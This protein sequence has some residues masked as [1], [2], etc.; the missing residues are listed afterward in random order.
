MCQSE[1]ILPWKWHFLEVP[2]IHQIM[3]FPSHCLS[4]TALSMPAKVSQL[5]SIKHKTIFW[6]VPEIPS[7]FSPFSLFPIQIAF[8]ASAWQL[9]SPAHPPTTVR[10]PPR[11]RPLSWDTSAFPCKMNSPLLFPSASTH[12]PKSSRKTPFQHISNHFSVS[13]P[14]FSLHSEKQNP[15]TDIIWPTPFLQPPPFL[16]WPTSV[17]W[18][19]CP[20][21]ILFLKLKLDGLSQ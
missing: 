6:Q 18:P 14:D 9:L 4:L 3:Y 19:L 20:G 10:G 13:N 17:K 16:H 12:A 15:Y 2:I 8:H 5:F 21:M 1:S 7:M 11:R